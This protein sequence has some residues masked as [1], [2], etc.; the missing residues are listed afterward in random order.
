M[1]AQRMAAWEPPADISRRR[2][3]RLAD[4]RAEREAIAAHLDDRF[5][6]DAARLHELRTRVSTVAILLGS[7]RGGTSAFKAALAEADGAVAMGGEHRFLF[8]LL[9]LNFP[10]HGELTE[11]ASTGPIP[12]ADREFL[13]AN[14][15]REARGP[16]ALTLDNET[17]ERF[18]WEAVL[19][20]RLQW[21]RIDATA[22]RLHALACDGLRDAEG[23]GDL[24]HPERV[25]VAVLRRFLGDGLP[26]NPYAYAL[27]PHL[28]RAAFPDAVPPDGPADDLI[29]EISPYL[30]FHPATRPDPAEARA[31]VIKASSDAFRIPLLIELFASWD[32]RVVHLVRNPVA[33]VN[34][35]IDG[36]AHHCFWQHDLATVG[37]PLPP[38]VPPARLAWNFDLFDGWQATLDEPI[39]ALC[40]R[41]W[42][43]SSR[44]ILEDL[45]DGLPVLRVRFEDFQRDRL[46]RAEV[47]GAAARHAGL[48]PGAG[49]ETAADA[50]VVV[51]QTAPPAPGRW[52]TTRPGLATW[53]DKP[54]VREVASR[55]GYTGD[56]SHSD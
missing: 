9:G 37:L 34:G 4:L 54:W 24:G 45:P 11:C 43:A 32:I 38:G 35:L 12:A 52:R 5:P 23:G 44:R 47:L 22:D 16:L 36:W 55:L 49:L 56:L 40:T 46:T 8:T 19:R 30:L 53:V 13:I 6:A 15:F 2:R 21:P 1:L 18:G 20:F 33:A 25:T 27:P 42:T 17:V 7:A 50:P 31:L 10:D 41:Q 26:V 39:E 29:I 3:A 51:N 48:G 28:V 14:L